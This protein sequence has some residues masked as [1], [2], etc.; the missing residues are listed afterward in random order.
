MPVI[1]VV[2][3]YNCLSL[4][5]PADKTGLYKYSKLCFI[6]IIWMNNMFNR[7]TNNAFHNLY[8]YIK[9]TA[10]NIGPWRDVLL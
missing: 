8:D 5:N 9:Y 1:L 7:Q 10:V 6:I 4:N 2:Y 3:V